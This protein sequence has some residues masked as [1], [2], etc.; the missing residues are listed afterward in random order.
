VQKQ[1]DTLQKKKLKPTQVLPTL[2]KEEDKF[3][4]INAT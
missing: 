2:Q 4:T 3:Q 1:V